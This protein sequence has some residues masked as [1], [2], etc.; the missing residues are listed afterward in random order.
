[1]T[2]DNVNVWKD[3]EF[4][5]DLDT[6]CTSYKISPMNKKARFKNP[7]NPKAPFKWFL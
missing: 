7:L 2:G 1:M 4:R 6:F 3:I 5:I